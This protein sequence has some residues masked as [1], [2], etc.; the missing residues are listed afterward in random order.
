MQY[1]N[2]IRSACPSAL[3]NDLLT[4]RRQSAS[5]VHPAPEGNPSRTEALTSTHQSPA[6]TTTSPSL[7]KPVSPSPFKLDW[8][9]TI[10]SRCQT[11][12]GGPYPSR[13]G[14]RRDTTGGH[15][16]ARSKIRLPPP[17]FKHKEPCMSQRRWSSV[18]LM[19]V[20]L[21]LGLV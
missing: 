13:L 2:R 3:R 20:K 1:L 11:P 9:V 6:H 17:L 5:A 7:G 10:A 19:S 18:P 14:N 4:C 15:E 21:N 8:L 12:A 16:K